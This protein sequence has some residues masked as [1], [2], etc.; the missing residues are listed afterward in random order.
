MAIFNP[1]NKMVGILQKWVLGY[2]FQNN[3]AID[4]PS[5]ETKDSRMAKTQIK[6]K[7]Y[8]TS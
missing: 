1:F 7:I 6:V 3:M 4:K 5:K 8:N 2:I